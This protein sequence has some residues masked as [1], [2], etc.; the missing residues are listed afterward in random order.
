MS[1][2]TT[3]PNIV[4]SWVK[5]ALWGGAIIGLSM[6]MGAASSMAANSYQH[7]HGQDH[8]KPFTPV[9]RIAQMN[10]V[11]VNGQ[12]DYTASY[13]KTRAASVALATYVARMQESDLLG[14][15][16]ITEIDWKLGGLLKVVSIP[17]PVPIM[18]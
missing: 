10:V 11:R 2:K 12:I 3:K 7:G 16:V 8:I 18:K 1:Q 9:S 17:E 13:A 15:D 6:T 5:K 4:G 14:L